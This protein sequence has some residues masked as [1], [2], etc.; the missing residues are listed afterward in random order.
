MSKP[1]KTRIKELL[2]DVFENAGMATQPGDLDIDVHRD[3]VDGVPVYVARIRWRRLHESVVPTEHFGYGSNQRL[4]LFAAMVA[5]RAN[6][7]QGA[8]FMLSQIQ[9]LQDS[10]DAKVFRTRRLET[11]AGKLPLVMRES[12]LVGSVQKRG[13]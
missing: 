7:V 11:V 9:D 4:A 8:G 10:L 13:Q 12:G 6:L 5:F 1:L 3:C 2:M